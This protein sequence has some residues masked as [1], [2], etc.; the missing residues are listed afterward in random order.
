MLYIINY[1]VSIILMSV[2][3]IYIYSAFNIVNYELF[4]CGFIHSIMSGFLIACFLNKVIKLR[5][6]QK[7]S[8]VLFFLFMHIIYFSASSLK[9]FDLQLLPMM[10]DDTQYRFFGDCIVF[11]AIYSSIIIWYFNVKRSK[12]SFYNTYNS[13]ININTTKILFILLFIV[14]I[15]LSISLYRSLYDGFT[16][17][18]LKNIITIVDCLL[19]L[20]IV[21]FYNKKN[22]SVVGII[23]LLVFILIRGILYDSRTN[24]LAPIMMIISLFY[25]NN[26]MNVKLIEILIKYGTI[27]I[28][29]FSLIYLSINRL[30]SGG[31]ERLKFLI[32]YRFDLSDFATTI[33][34]N[35]GINFDLAS[36]TDAFILNIPTL[37]YNDKLNN[38]SYDKYYNTMIGNYGLLPGLDYTDT[39]F[40]MG[41]MLFG[42]IGF[43][44]ILPLMTYIFVR[45]EIFLDSKKYFGF[46][47]RFFLI[48]ILISIETEWVRFF[49]NLRNLA[50]LAILAILLPSIMVKTKARE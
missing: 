5:K 33:C 10:I 12:L 6:Q 24:M 3:T 9:Y 30:S 42:W 48:I 13:D 4:F 36:L 19:I 46:I 25:I 41:A 44:F 37:I 14:D 39:Y 23:L 1:F 7:Y 47:N 8:I 35:M 34:N 21:S 32:S 18:I 43:I 26:K 11:F 27:I 38:I 17:A 2:L 50:I 45:L 49:S 15:F 29:L 28:L 31:L 20:T 22:G 40:S 16:L